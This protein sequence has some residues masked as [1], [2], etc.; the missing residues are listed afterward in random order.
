MKLPGQ[1]FLAER[2]ATR[3]FESQESSFRAIVFY[4]EG[5]GDWPHLGPIALAL[6]DRHDQRVSYLTS[7]AADPGLAIEHPNFRAFNIGSG[8]ARTVLFARMDCRHFVMTLPDLGNLWL[9]RSPLPVHYVYVFHSMNSTHTSYRNGAFDN[10]DTILCVGPHH[11][12][13]IRR[14]ERL[15][16]LPAKRLVEH[17]S[18]KL[19]TVMDEF[20]SLGHVQRDRVLT[21]LVAPTWG[22]SSLIEQPVGREL[23]GALIEAGIRTT[24]RLHPMTSRRFP[25]LTADLQVSVG[26]HAL[27]Q[28]EQ[29]MSATESWARADL[30]ISD[31]SGAAAEFA[32]AT[33]KPVVYVDTP[34]KLMNPSWAEIGLPALEDR[35]RSQLGVVVPIE[36]A[37]GIPR[38]A[39]QLVSSPAADRDAFA[40]LRA[41]TVFNVARSAE[42]AA[43]HLSQLV[44]AE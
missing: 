39:R 41:R 8:T 29:N 22:P 30:M 40:A 18:V 25:R 35:L 44:A 2:K 34:P 38:I 15:Y 37:S 6:I 7:D 33:G 4:S 5:A 13:E 27:L 24:L 43:R 28:V 9:K 19:D 17:G 3:T 20:A 36:Q 31:W 42:V 12:E 10:F 11:V 14:T 21:A 1:A 32:F 26:G 23:I 16:G